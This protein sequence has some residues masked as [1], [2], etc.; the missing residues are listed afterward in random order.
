M[1]MSPA[2]P[3]RGSKMPRKAA[4]RL[5]SASSGIPSAS[6]S[7]F[8]F[9]GFGSANV[10]VVTEK[11]SVTVPTAGTL[12]TTAGNGPVVSPNRTLTSGTTIGGS[13]GASGGTNGWYRV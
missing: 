4:L 7:P 12:T 2:L 13:D 6:E 3:G 10:V 9:E 5:A 1:S 11:F 8:A